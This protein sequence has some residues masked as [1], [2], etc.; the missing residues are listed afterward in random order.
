M[1]MQPLGNAFR[2]FYRQQHPEVEDGDIN[3]LEALLA[4]RFMLDPDQEANEIQ[5]LDAERERLLQERLPDFQ[6][7]WEEFQIVERKSRS[8]R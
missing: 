1:I 4:Q 5:R 8:R 6:R 2:Q 7:A 3:R